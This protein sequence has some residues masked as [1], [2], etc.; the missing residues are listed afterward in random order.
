MLN[1]RILIRCLRY[2]YSFGRPAPDLTWVTDLVGVSGTLHP[3]HFPYLASLGVSSVVDL[4]REAMHDAKLL[5][6]CGIR[7]LRLPTTDHYPP[8]LQHMQQGARWVVDEIR[9]KRKT[10]VHCKE[11]I[12]R[13]VCVVCCALMLRGHD[14]VRALELVK[15]KRWGVSLNARQIRGLE[16]FERT[17]LTGRQSLTSVDDAVNGT[18]TYNC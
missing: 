14:L 1:R 12:G 8:S 17:M 15:A 10:L 2:A 18:G 11:G 7:Y 5:T 6:E 13:S 9:A 16:E 3:R 4:R